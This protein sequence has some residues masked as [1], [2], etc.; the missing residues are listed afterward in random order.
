MFRYDMTKQ[1][2]GNRSGRISNSISHNPSITLRNNWSSEVGSSLGVRTTFR[3]QERSGIKT[4]SLLIAPNF[5]IDYD[6]HVSGDMG[7]PLI[8]KKIKLDHDLDMSNTFSIM[9]RREKLG[10][11]RDEKSEQYGTSLDVSYN[12]RERIRATLRFSIDY[13]HDRIQEDADY[14]SVSGSLMLRGEFK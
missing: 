9:I 14:L 10:V 13:N 5:N 11:N 12:L 8:K 4:K 7:L 3:N 6:L 2:M 1:D